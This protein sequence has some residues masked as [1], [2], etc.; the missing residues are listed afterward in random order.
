[1]PNHSAGVEQAPKTEGRT[2]R[3]WARFYDTASWLMSFG[4]DA[5]TNREIVARAGIKPGDRVLDVGCGTGAQAIPSAMIAGAGNV[6][7]IDPSPEMIDVAR[8]K[9][10]KKRV[11]VDFRL[12]AIEERLPQADPLSRLFDVVLSSFMLHHLPEDVTR[13]GFAQIRRVLKPGGRF[14]AADLVS[15][16][17]LVGRVIGFFGHAHKL[18]SLD[19]IKAA[20]SETGFEAV[21]EL[22]SSQGHLF[23]LI[24]KKPA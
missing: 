24:A 18:K 4:Q 19:A 17:S 22:P 12:A 15:G 16:R 6:T 5:R 21:E 3:W 1:M 10:A 9:A 14:L 13:A 2:I 8:R 11:E 20:L 23:F 7:G